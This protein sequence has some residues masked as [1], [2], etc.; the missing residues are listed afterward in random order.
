MLQ[1]FNRVLGVLAGLLI[2]SAAFAATLLPVGFISWD[3]NIPGSVGTF[4]IVNLTGPNAAP[5]DF[6][7]TTPLSLSSLSLTV[8]F[9]DG[10]T[11]LFGSS[12]FTLGLDG[13][14]FDGGVIPIGG[15]NPLPTDAVLT[16]VF[17]TTTVNISGGGTETILPGFMAHIIPS[18]GLTLNDLDLAV[19]YATVDAGTGLPE[20]S[21]LLLAG[22]GL[23]GLMWRAG[24]RTF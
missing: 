23:L 24:Q 16:G 3:V 12:Y 17:S 14:S 20:P 8:Q 1:I 2:G 19:I 18:A 15:T 4:D 10:S 13:L 22:L 9:S 7:I 21:S 6:S 11:Q 5:P